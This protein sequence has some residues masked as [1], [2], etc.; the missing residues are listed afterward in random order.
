MK[1]MVNNRKA[2]MLLKMFNI[3]N[4]TVFVLDFDGIF[5]ST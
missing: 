2:Y 5:I 4:R 3:A 1:N